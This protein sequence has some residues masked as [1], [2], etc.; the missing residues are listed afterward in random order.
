MLVGKEKIW[1]NRKSDMR[2]CGL[3]LYWSF[4]VLLLLPLL[5]HHQSKM[6][7]KTFNITSVY[8]CRTLLCPLWSRTRRLQWPKPRIFWRAT[9]ILLRTHTPPRCLPMPWLCCAAHMHRWLCA[10]STTWPSHK[11]LPHTLYHP[12][13]QWVTGGSC[14]RALLTRGPDV[15]PGARESADVWLKIA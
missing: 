11:V 10:A 8:H 5:F 2:E 14:V 13:S 1:I 4:P 6:L 15:S 9:R 7:V 3:L 12:P